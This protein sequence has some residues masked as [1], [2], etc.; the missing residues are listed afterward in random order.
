MDTNTPKID[1]NCP[2]CQAT[3][4]TYNYY[5]NLLA[6]SKEANAIATEPNTAEEET[7]V[8]IQHSGSP[9][10]QGEHPTLTAMLTEP[11][12]SKIKWFIYHQ[13]ADHDGPTHDGHGWKRY[14]III[15]N[16]PRSDT[17]TRRFT[18]RYNPSADRFADD[19]DYDQLTNPLSSPALEIL[20]AIQN[21]ERPSINHA[22]GG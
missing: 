16:V 2:G 12:G 15:H 6:Q 13:I 20:A 18:L 19:H 22:K 4:A 14:L 8:K 3:A 17:S 10:T 7:L 21:H 9:D 5:F 1:W 11:F